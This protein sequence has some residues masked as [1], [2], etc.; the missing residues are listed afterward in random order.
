MEVLPSQL[1]PFADRLAD[2]FGPEERDRI[3][4]TMTL[5]KRVGVFRNPLLQSAEQERDTAAE[6]QPLPNLPD[7]FW[8]PAAARERLVSSGPV[9]AGGLYLLNPSSYLAPLLL[10]PTP[11]EEVLDLAAAP[12]GKTLVMAA[13]MQNRGRI[14]AVESV[15]PRFHRMRANLARCGVTLVQTYLDD[16][17]RIGG[18]VPQR[19]DRVLLDAPCSSEARI[20]LD[21]PTSYQHWSPRKV[22]ETARKQRGLIR[23]GFAALKPGGSLL[24][25]TCAFAPEENELVV[26]HL[27]D[28]ESAAR[29]LPLAQAVA[30]RRHTTDPAAPGW[31]SGLLHWRGRALD[32]SISGAVRLLPDDLWDGFFCCLIRKEPQ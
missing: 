14:A 1:E 23:S 7:F 6:L 26:Q 15:R 30:A 4:A 27:L 17:R 25:C 22:R 12:G 8:A 3:L 20:R 32:G 28:S 2:M 18:K 31:C 13:L 11:E 10:A 29:V 21:Q 9:V 19:F 24:Y 16:G 5:R